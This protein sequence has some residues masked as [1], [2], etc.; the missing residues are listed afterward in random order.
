MVQKKSKKSDDSIEF[1]LSKASEKISNVV[2]K[3]KQ[4]PNITKI[5]I[6]TVLLIISLSFSY[7]LRSHSA[8]LDVTEQWA[9]QAINNA[10]IN[11]AT[12]AVKEQ[13]PSLQGAAL[14]ARV[15]EVANL[16]RQQAGDLS[17]QIQGQ[18]QYFRERMQLEMADGSQ[19][20]Y[21]LAIDPW[22]YYRYTQ[23]Y[24]D[25]GHEGDEL[26]DGKM[27]DYHMLAPD[28]T[29]T[30]ATFH[31]RFSAFWHKIYSFFNP[32]AELLQ[33]FFWVPVVISMLSVIPAFFIVYR[34]TNYLGGFISAMVVAIHPY[35]LTRTAAGFSDTD[36]YNVFFPLL[37]TWLLM[38]SFTANNLRNK[39]IL[40]ILAGFSMAAFPFAWGGWWY[41][42]DF[43]VA[44]LLAYF[45]FIV[46]E[47][48]LSATKWD[49]KYKLL[50][51]IMPFIGLFLNLFNSMNSFLGI[52]GQVII[53][54]WGL[55]FLYDFYKFY[56]S[57]EE[58]FKNSV[59][60]YFVSAFSFI[61]SSSILISFFYSL[62]TLLSAIKGPLGFTAIQTS[63]KADL[64]PNVYTTVAELNKANLSQIV[65]NIGFNIHAGNLFFFLAVMGIAFSFIKKKLQ[66]KDWL[67][68]GLT[69]IFA[70][71]LLQYTSGSANT[72]L[73][74]LSIPA[75]IGAY[76]SI[77]RDVDVKYA[78]ILT[79]WFI[80]TFYASTQGIRFILLMVPVFAV[81][82]GIFFGQVFRVLE[83]YAVSEFKLSGRNKIFFSLCF[84]LVM[85][86]FLIQPVKAGL[87]VGQNEVPSFDDAWW[88]SLKAIEAD[89]QP[90]A[91]INS[92]WDFGHWFKAVADRAVTFDGASQNTPQAH[93]I[94]R[95]LSASD[96]KETIGILRMLDCGANGAYEM[97]E[98]QGMQT[99]RAINLVKEVIL[100]D[101]EDAKKVLEN[102]DVKNVDEFLE[103]THCIPPENY[104]I[105]S[106]DMVGK[107]G[108]WSHFGNW[109][110]NKAYL[111][112]AVKKNDV[113]TLSS[114][115]Q[116]LDM[117]EADVNS[118]ISEIR[119]WRGD[120]YANNAIGP[121]A[122]YVANGR[123]FP[124]TLI[125]E[126]YKCTIGMGIGTDQ[127]GNNNVI[128]YLNININNLQDSSITLGSY[129]SSSR[130]LGGMDSV[131]AN[132][133]LA[134]EDT[135]EK[136]SFEN[137]ALG[138]I[139]FI[140][141]TKNNKVILAS[142]PVSDSTF[143]KLFYLD[144]RG[145]ENFEL[146][147][148]EISITGTRILVWKVKW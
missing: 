94:G 60:R 122:G 119:S 13:Y 90:D 14:D 37:I 106:G 141:D 121:F 89:S 120:D 118:L 110:F 62:N 123:S 84:F 23:N 50:Y 86:L 113:A 71:I 9:E 72:F 117:N 34:K 107:S 5:A 24:L 66:G 3:A 139:D 12:A 32:N 132:I 56:I 19:Q 129:D 36:A 91:I 134:N 2:K 98:S 74:L 136:L 135:V 138:G 1:D 22:Q 11:Q 16:L 54:A 115:A 124:C 20:T 109:D 116:V 77:G 63:T 114:A 143:T 100:L 41:I 76:L 18:A 6:I 96:E 40:G 26:V 38:E 21:L 73:I 53:L 58:K 101:K 133:V 44:G 148:D 65:S 43:L 93:W 70:L 78:M 92:W 103:L 27:W 51:F 25:H 145:T 28:G 52:A 10:I 131:P 144:G 69:F 85:S 64:W 87:Q 46:I 42:F 48:K 146:I 45:W 17:P 67:I 127:V 112:N 75:L 142:S 47:K 102:N 99:V 7:S 105:T 79:V 49:L 104:F 35:F 83:N 97:L 15:N 140:V 81:S 29:T 125:N 128:E 33:S 108:V 30:K 68:V 95:A 111:Y 82:L 80:G 126:T 59:N 137:S 4:S 130:R 39:V 31:T 55:Y 57:K 8:G 88:A 61:A 147:S